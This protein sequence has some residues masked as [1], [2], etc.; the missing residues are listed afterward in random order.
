MVYSILKKYGI[1]GGSLDQHF[2]V[3]EPILASIAEAADLQGD[4]VVLEIGGGIGNLT[5]RLVAQAGRV[6]VIERDPRLVAVLQDRFHEVSNIDIIEGDAMK[7]DL[8]AFNKVVANLPYSISSPITFRLLT[9]GFEKGILMY[10]YE[11]ARRMVEVPGSKNYGRLSVD[12]QYFAD[13]RLL[14][15]ISP[16]AFTPAPKVWSAVVEMIPIPPVFEVKDEQLFFSIVEA[17]F[18]Q[19]RKKIKNALTKFNPHLADQDSII[20]LI[21]EDFLG[22]RAEQL[23]P[24]DFATISNIIYEARDN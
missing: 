6:I 24:E 9:H 14:R 4:D 3:N 15:K 10:Q 13:V 19:R 20:Q 11:F 22:K 21:P 2:L 7:V 17:A 23:F 16:S 8:P 18:G 12:T 1:R 5:E